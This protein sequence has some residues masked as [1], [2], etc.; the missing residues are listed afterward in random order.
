[1]DFPFVGQQGE[2]YSSALNA[3]RTVNLYPVTD[4][5]GKRP[6]ALYGTPGSREFV[7]FSVAPVCEW[8]PLDTSG[9]SYAFV[10]TDA[11][12]ESNVI[13]ASQGVGV[14]ADWLITVGEAVWLRVTSDS[15]DNT[16]PDGPSNIPRIQWGT[17]ASG[18]TSVGDQPNVSGLLNAFAPSPLDADLTGDVGDSGLQFFPGEN[19]AGTAVF[20]IEVYMCDGVPGVPE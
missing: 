16:G 13:S 14:V 10:A 4:P 3:I 18:Y 1:M 5:A 20:S 19:F 8:V 17:A 6:V 2:G 9:V 15:F 7:S 12:M 11:V